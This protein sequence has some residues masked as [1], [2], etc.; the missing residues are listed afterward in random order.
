MRAQFKR[1]PLLPPDHITDLYSYSYLTVLN[2]GHLY[3]LLLWMELVCYF[4][5]VNN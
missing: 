1:L 4:N 5:K 2:T 3:K